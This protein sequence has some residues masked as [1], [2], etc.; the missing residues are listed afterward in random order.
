MLKRL[1]YTLLVSVMG[2]PVMAQNVQSP[3]QFLGYELGT[4]YTS[5]YKV[6]EYFTQVANAAPNNV[7]YT[8]YGTTNEGRALTLAYISSTENMQNLE[9]IRKDNMNR[10]GLTK[11]TTSTNVAIVWLSYNVHGNEPSSSEAAMQTIYDL[12]TKQTAG[13]LKNT[14]VIIDPCLNPDGRDRYVNWFNTT[15]GAK[16]N[17]NPYAREH[18]EPWPGGRVNHYYF[19]L[20]RDW[21]WQ[22]QI[23]TQKRIVVYNKWMPHVHVDFHEQGINE[24]Y[25]FAPAAEPLHE[26]VT[27]WQRDFQVTIGKNNA[28]YFDDNG[29]YYFTKERF[30]LFYPSYGDTYPTYNGS[31]GMTYEQGGHSRGGLTIIKDNMDTLTLVDRVKH[32]TTTGLSTVEVS[33]QHAQKLLDNFKQYFDNSNKGIGS[34]YKNYVITTNDQEKLNEVTTL[35]KNNEIQYTVATKVTGS[36]L[37]YLTNTVE[38]INTEKYAVVVSAIQPKSLLAKVLLEPQSKLSD[39]ATYDITAWSIPYAYGVKAYGA[40]DVSVSNATNTAAT[41]AIP[42][43]NYALM[44]R[45]NSLNSA[46]LLADLLQNGT[47]IKMNEKIISYKGQNFPRGTILIPK[48]ENAKNWNT[49]EQI[50]TQHNAD[51]V[52][53]Q[54][55]FVDKGP[56][57]GSPD[58][59]DIAAP[60]IAC[61][62]GNSS[63][64]NA[65]GAIWHFYDKVLNYP[66]T[67]INGDDLSVTALKGF[68]VLI[69]PDG[70]YS[71]LTDK[72]T[73]EN[74]RNWIR[75]GGRVIVIDG[76]AIQMANSEGG[77]KTKKADEEKEKEDDKKKDEYAN[78]KK[79]ETRDRDGLID[80]IPGAIYRVELDETHPLAFGYGK[81]YFTLKQNSE[82]LEFSKEAWNVGVVKKNAKVSGHAG[83]RAKEKIK[84]GSVLSV[85]EMGRGAVIYFLDDPIFRSFWQNGKL[86]FFNA[87][88]LVGNNAVRL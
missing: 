68:D 70:R 82:L 64:E 38:S 3:Q 20:N 66:L 17:A 52:A 77:I 80:Y 56:D 24:P 46:M 11:G 50:L 28:R 27:P 49:I 78:I 37:N 9:T 8:N 26:V 57:M 18:N 74:L 55:G 45:Y 21:A 62:T 58:I 61:V 53:L 81:S 67:M 32:H 84:D 72:T 79:Y 23:E 42:A 75:G 13:W 86:L 54:T 33:S 69:V 43:T 4:K 10:T 14:V 22:T 71:F 40:N 36:G 16:G 85:Q 5:H 12:V 6:V 47:R 65:S 30:D 60:K 88:F 63:N 1:L 48:K 7:K 41:R 39:T 51:A 59:K 31:I 83:Y 76:A 25:Y 73:N 44:V 35:F 87:A 34:Q 19:D 29:W 15:V 2:L